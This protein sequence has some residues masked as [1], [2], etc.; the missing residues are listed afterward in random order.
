[1]SSSGAKVIVHRQDE[2]PFIEDVGTEIETAMATSIGMHL[3]RARSGFRG[4]REG[5]GLCAGAAKEVPLSGRSVVF[6][7]G[8]PAGHGRGHP[9]GRLGV[10]VWADKDREEWK[11]PSLRQRQTSAPV[12][13]PGV[14]P[15]LHI[16][17][18]C[19]QSSLTPFFRAT[20]RL[21][22]QG[23]HCVKATGRS[24]GC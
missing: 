7:R 13:L 2:Y 9:E 6:S 14:R 20:W 18:E 22:R 19:K 1:M 21:R 8:R 16:G 5:H 24:P 3:V 12:E 4:R 17:R 23:S 10:P 11:E 15:A